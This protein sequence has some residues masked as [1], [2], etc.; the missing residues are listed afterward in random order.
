MGCKSKAILS[1]GQTEVGT[2]GIMSEVR[3]LMSEVK[4]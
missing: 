1:Y 4:V 2:R 3:G